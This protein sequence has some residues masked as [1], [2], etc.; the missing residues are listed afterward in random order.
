VAK[1]GGGFEDDQKPIRW[2]FG[3]HCFR[4]RGQD[5]VVKVVSP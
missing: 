5:H 4:V 3:E 1:A 2:L